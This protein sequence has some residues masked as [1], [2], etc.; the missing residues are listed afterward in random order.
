[1]QCVTMIDLTAAYALEDLIKNTT[2]KGVDVFITNSRGHIKVMLEKIDFINHVGHNVFK[3]S[4]E[5]I[6]P[7]IANQ[8]NLK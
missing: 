6:Y 7:I 1:M 8:Y 2:L 4:S 3:D 5:S